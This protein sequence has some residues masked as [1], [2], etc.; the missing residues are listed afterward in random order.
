[1]EFY[2]HR[3]NTSTWKILVFVFIKITYFFEHFTQHHLDAPPANNTTA[4]TH[5]CLTD[6][7]PKGY[8]TKLQCWAGGKV[9]QDLHVLRFGKVLSSLPI[10]KRE[11]TASQLNSEMVFNLDVD[12]ITCHL[13][14]FLLKQD[15]SY[16]SIFLQSFFLTSNAKS[17]ILSICLL[18]GRPSC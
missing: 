4:A 17:I 7:A 12:W 2:L 5:C 10:Q 3:W 9:Y 13:N 14:L 1:M 11:P 18:T 15:L 16:R 8:E 6:P